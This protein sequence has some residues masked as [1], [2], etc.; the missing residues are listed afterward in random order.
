VKTESDLQANARVEIDDWVQPDYIPPTMR[1]QYTMG[2]WVTRPFDNVM[3]VI[4]I[5]NPM[6]RRNDEI[7]AAKEDAARKVAMYHGIEGNIEATLSTG[8]NFFN[9][10]YDYKVELEYDPNHAKYIDQLMYD[11]QYDVLV[12]DQ[13]IF[14]R[15]Q[16]AAEVKLID[17]ITEKNANGR[18]NW[19]FNRNMPQLDGFVTATGYARNQLR[20][21]DTVFKATES[22]AA[23]MIEDMSIQIQNKMTILD[24][25]TTDIV[26]AV[27]MGMLSHFHVIEFWIDTDSGYVY[28]LAIARPMSREL[29]IEKEY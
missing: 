5:S 18:P 1:E 22:A 6:L 8:T 11:P 7:I 14:V 12:T 21:K 19:T 20:L 16:Y 28:T 13:A 2:Y 23:R 4:G 24:Q 9:H 15:F 17:Y 25:F 29:T 3:T 27:S 10:I 26:Y